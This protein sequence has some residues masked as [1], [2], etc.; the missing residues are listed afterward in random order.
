GAGLIATNSPVH[1]SPITRTFDFS[2]SD[3]TLGSPILQLGAG[4]Y[5]PV[6]GS[7]TVTFDPTGGD[8]SGQT[9]GIT[10]NSINVPLSSQISFN[11]TMAIDFLCVG[12]IF[13]SSCGLAVFQNPDDFLVGIR[14]ASTSTPILTSVGYTL[15]SVPPGL[16]AQCCF[17]AN[18]RSVSA[19]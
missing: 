4:P 12:G 19:T 1:A 11:Y 16:S 8:V 3:V 6:L 13:A 17:Q 14:G 5:D 15:S 2:G 18:S 10:L 9:T 7:V